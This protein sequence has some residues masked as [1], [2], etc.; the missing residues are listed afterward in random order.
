M[1]IHACVFIFGWSI[2]IITHMLICTLMHI[3]NTY[4]IHVNTSIL[5]YIVFTDIRMRF[6][7]R[8]VF[9]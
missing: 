3:I 9:R 5:L 8:I 4:N 2:Y 1:L 7:M 6:G